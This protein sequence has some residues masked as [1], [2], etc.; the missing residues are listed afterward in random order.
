VDDVQAAPLHRYRCARCGYGATCRREPEQCPMCQRSEWHE[1]GWSPFTAL[2]ADLDPESA[3]MTREMN[4]TG[5]YPGV[6]LS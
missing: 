2:S 3:P 6:P 4:E 1:E 5:F